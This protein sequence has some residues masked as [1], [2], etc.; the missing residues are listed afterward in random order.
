[1]PVVAGLT[2]F[3]CESF[4]DRIEARR[5]SFSE[6][7]DVAVDGTVLCRFEVS[8]Q[9][10]HVATTS[11]PGTPTLLGAQMHAIVATEPVAGRRRLRWQGRP[12]ARYLLTVPA[13]LETDTNR[14]YQEV[15][16]AARDRSLIDATLR[17]GR[18]ATSRFRI[19][20]VGPVDRGSFRAMSPWCSTRS[21]PR[22]VR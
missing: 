14:R 10:E 8:E 19:S 3:R 13:K 12:P 5:R 11:R 6:G 20:H 22:P 1:M 17:A 18:P 16:E 15:L 21:V 9:G 4:A 2:R 7:V